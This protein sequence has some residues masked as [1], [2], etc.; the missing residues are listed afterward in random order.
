MSVVTLALRVPTASIGSL[1]NCSLSERMTETQ[2][3]GFRLVLGSIRGESW[4][5]EGLI[6][7]LLV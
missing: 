2:R 7:V 1:S 4:D 3:N 5:P 6:Y